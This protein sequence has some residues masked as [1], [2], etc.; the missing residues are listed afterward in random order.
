MFGGPT[1][2]DSRWHWCSPRAH[3]RR[4]SR[5]GARLR[6]I[7]KK[8]HFHH[9]PESQHWCQV[10]GS[11]KRRAA[12]DAV[13]R[14]TRES[15]KDLRSTTA[16]V[17]LMHGLRRFTG[18]RNISTTQ[19]SAVGGPQRV[20][21]PNGTVTPRKYCGDQRNTSQRYH[22]CEPAYRKSSLPREAVATRR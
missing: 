20:R 14:R 21:N 10:P 18:R 11:R 8:R 22:A 13:V 7:G 17:R 9:A 19:D 5:R 4:K 15:N 16:P 2:V 3:G 12:Q 1:R 6:T